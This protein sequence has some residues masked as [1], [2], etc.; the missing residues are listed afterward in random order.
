MPRM[1][2]ALTLG[3]ATAT[4]AA[5]LVGCSSSGG[6]SGSTGDSSG[7]GGGATAGS[8]SDYTIGVVVSQTGG[9]SQLGVGELRGAKLAAAA[10]NAKGGVDGHKIVIKSADDQ[11][12]PD[13]ALQQAR[14][15]MRDNVAAIVGPSVVA[16]CN[17]V[18]PLVKDKGPVNYCL[19]PGIDPSGYVFSASVATPDLAQ[20]VLAYWKSKGIA[21]IGLMYTTDGS[22]EQGAGAVKK[23]APKVGSTIVASASYDPTAVSVTSQLQKVM[24]G[25]PQALIVWA[26]GTP[27]GVALKAIQ[28]SG[29]DLP[30][31]TTDGNLANAF[32]KR[33]AAYMP[34]TLLIPATRDFWWQKLP[35]S[36]AT[37]KLEKK[38]HDAY[39]AK[40]NEPPDFGPGVGYDAVRVIAEALGKA[41]SADPGKLRSAMEAIT[42]FEGVAGQYNLSGSDHRGLG[43]N[44]V[45][46][47]KAGKGTFT[48]VATGKSQ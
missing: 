34:K 31:A 16:D 30:V 40:Y 45:G 43:I 29:T 23:A 26:T 17:A 4:A 44:D 14:D 3:V 27:V 13:Q 24:A 35:T 12:K 22:G 10:I 42:G 5:V 33:A 47:V 46:I 36:S 20:K 1:S 37:Y 9:A 8:G 38:Y 41:G 6:S 21:K 39:Q 25:H 19:S 48:A 15:M 18:V 2:K 32:L 11:T 7:S 28:Q